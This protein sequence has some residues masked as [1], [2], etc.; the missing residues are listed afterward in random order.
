[1]TP[2][3]PFG[4]GTFFVDSEVAPG[5]YRAIDPSESCRWYQLHGFGERYGRDLLEF[6]GQRPNSAQRGDDTIVDISDR[7]A[8]FVSAGCGT[9]SND[10]S[11]VATPGQPFPDGTYIVGIDVAPGRYRPSTPESC[12][13][14]RLK[15]LAASTATGMVRYYWAGQGSVADIAPEDAGFSSEPAGCG[16]TC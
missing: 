15:P 11:P 3:Q 4:E 6:G 2:G 1:M 13:W 10:L 14:R 12:T 8:G 5:R 9:W 7:S 16:A